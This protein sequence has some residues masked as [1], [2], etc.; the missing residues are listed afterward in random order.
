MRER[1]GGKERERKEDRERER[2]RKIERE[3]VE[4]MFSFTPHSLQ[5]VKLHFGCK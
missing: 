5:V 1:K 4:P 3:R 2:E